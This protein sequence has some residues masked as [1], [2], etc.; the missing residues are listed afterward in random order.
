MSWRL[1]LINLSIARLWH[2]LTLKLT[3]FVKEPC[4]KTGDGLIQVRTA[5]VT[6]PFI[7]DSFVCDQ[8][9]L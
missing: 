9:D 4:F 3:D 5:G 2:Q 6:S 8:I 7:S 1:T